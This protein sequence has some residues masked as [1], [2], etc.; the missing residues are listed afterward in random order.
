HIGLWMNY[1]SVNGLDF[2][3]NST[4][5]APEKRN[6]YGSIR[7]D[8]FIEKKAGKDSAVI[9]VSASWLNP[10]GKILLKE[11]TR[12][13][14]TVKEKHFFIERISTLTAQE[15]DVHFKDVKDGFFAIRVA[16]EL[17]MP[18]T[19]QDVFTDSHGNKT[20]VEKMRSEERR[21]GKEVRS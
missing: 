18:S 8:Q 6:M 4:D 21:V 15:E 5:I 2:W 3:N 17:E 20:A 1:E 19:Q 11:N 16:R 14:F 9:A 13:L 7:H 12:Y 10:A